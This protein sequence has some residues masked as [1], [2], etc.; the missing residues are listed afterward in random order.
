M[1]SRKRTASSE[2][3]DLFNE[4]VS[5]LLP[6]RL[7][8]EGRVLGSSVRQLAAPASLQICRLRPFSVRRVNGYE[9]TLSSGQAL[10]IISARTATQIDADLVLLV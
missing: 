8:I 3:D 5:L 4:T 10:K 9:A 2:Q 1:A 6:P 7:A